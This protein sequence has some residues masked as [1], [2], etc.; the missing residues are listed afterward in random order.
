MQ[1]KAKENVFPVE[2]CGIKNKKSLSLGM[3]LNSSKFNTYSSD[4]P[5]QQDR[6]RIIHLQASQSN[7]N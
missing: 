6:H 2:I 7:R 5:N 3:L 1:C 4:H